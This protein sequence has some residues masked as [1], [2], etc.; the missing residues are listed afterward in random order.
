MLALNGSVS[1]ST[2][3]SIGPL[4]TPKCRAGGGSPALLAR[5]HAR[6][7][8]DRGRLRELMTLAASSPESPAASPGQADRASS[9]PTS[10]PIG[11]STSNHEAARQIPHLAG[12]AYPCLLL[13]RRLH[14]P[15]VRRLSPM[16]PDDRSPPGR[17]LISA[18]L[19]RESLIPGTP[20][21]SLMSTDRPQDPARP[22][23]PRHTPLRL[24]PSPSLFRSRRSTPLPAV[25]SHR[26]RQARLLPLPRFP[27]ARPPTTHL[28]RRSQRYPQVL[29]LRTPKHSN[30]RPDLSC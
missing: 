13:F 5:D 29:P 15:A 7:W 23:P 27:C 30:H 3:R 12:C 2:T 17:R 8:N 21:R 6:G 9:S 16:S 14:P 25:T 24:P 4:Q 10:R 20:S 18:G 11:P 1:T 26:S 28:R 22:T 19:A